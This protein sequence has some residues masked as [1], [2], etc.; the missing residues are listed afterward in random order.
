MRLKFIGYPKQREFLRAQERV[1]VFQAGAGAGKTRAGSFWALTRALTQPGSRGMIV[2]HTHPQMSQSLVP[3]LEDLGRKTNLDRLWRWNTHEKVIKL[4]NGS[5][6]FLRSADSPSSLLGADLAWGWGDEVALWKR[7]A[8]RFF[9][10]RIRQPGFHQQ[11]AVTMT[12]KGR[13]WAFKALGTSS[14]NR[15][16]IHATTADNVY[17]GRAYT[18]SL[19]A[20]YGETTLFYA[21]EAGGEY[22]TYEG[23]IYAVFGAENRIQ[24]PQATPSFEVV[25][26]GIDWGWTNPAVILL[27]GRDRN[28][29]YHAF[30]ET[31]VTHKTPDEL[32]KVASALQKK[33][34]VSM[35]YADPSEPGNIETMIREGV[36]CKAADN[37][38]VP[39]IA[40]VNGLFAN[41]RLFVHDLECPRLI[42]EIEEYKW[43]TGADGEAKPDVPDDKSDHVM[44]ALRY[45]TYSFRSQSEAF[46]QVL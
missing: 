42:E 43:K 31:Y 33:Y 32:A 8:W 36:S 26:G 20:E 2:S 22:V 29:T 10:G 45:A 39:G 41:R 23:L 1:V 12:P 21:Q 38:I 4:W 5:T 15:R 27:V 3:Y 28:G 44:D 24:R 13:N 9:V 11:V 37:A 40:C 18:D 46:M 6:I 14:P 35:F 25:I 34:G 17:L 16:I 19:K 30:H 7:D